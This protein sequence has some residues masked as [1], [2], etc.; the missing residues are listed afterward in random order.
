VG[1]AGLRPHTAEA[2]TNEAST[3]D[4]TGKV[5]TR[6][7][8]RRSSQAAEEKIDQIVIFQAADESA[9]EPSVHVRRPK[10]GSAVDR[11]VE[12]ASQPR[13]SGRGSASRLRATARPALTGGAKGTGHKARYRAATVR[14]RL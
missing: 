9:W 11:S 12:D 14:E 10:I 5:N 1:P 4:E 13:P 6:R 8:A 3:N 7:K 2:S